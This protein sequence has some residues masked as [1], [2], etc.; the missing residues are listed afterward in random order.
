M[1]LLFECHKY[2]LFETQG[3]NLP[4]PICT[5]KSFLQSN[6]VR[7]LMFHIPPPMLN[8]LKHIDLHLNMDI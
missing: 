4:C 7:Y 3:Y 8:E 2:Y 1:L 6:K 5:T